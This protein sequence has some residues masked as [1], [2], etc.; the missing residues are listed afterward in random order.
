MATTIITYSADS[1][2]FNET[3]TPSITIYDGDGSIVDTGSMTHLVNGKYTYIFTATVGTSYF[4]KIVIEGREVNTALEMASAVTSGSPSEG[5][6]ITTGDYTNSLQVVRVAGIGVEIVDE[7]VG[8]GDNSEVSFDLDND[9]IIASSYTLYHG[10]SDSNVMSD[11]TETTHYSLDK[12]SGRVVLTTAGKTELGTDI[13][14]GKY[15]HS[16]KMSDTLI[17]SLIDKAEAELEAYTERQWDE[18]TEITEFFDGEENKF[19]KYP[20]TDEPFQGKYT[21]PDYIV[22]SKG[23]VTSVESVSFIVRGQTLT[24]VWTYDGTYTDNTSEANTPGGTSFLAFGSSPTTSDYLYCGMPF[25]FLSS[26]LIFDVVGAGS[27]ALVLEYWNGSAWTAISSPTDNTTNYT[28]D[29]KVSWTMPSGWAKT[30]VNGSGEYY[31][32]RFSYSG[33]LSTVPKIFEL[34]P[35]SDDVIQTEISLANID[36][37]SYGK[38][39]LLKNRIPNGPRIVKVVYNYGANE[40]PVLVQELAALYAS[41]RVFANITGGSYD[42]VTGYT[43]GSKQVS[44]GEVYVNVREVVRQ[45]TVRIDEIKRLVGGRGFFCA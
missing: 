28:K 39:S 16:P 38:L 30:T 5:E 4:A 37:A 12:A 18:L 24:Q 6:T 25:K 23:P 7:N 27:Q 34:A 44:I 8:T 11:L 22:L 13:L 31:Y 21:A 2:N 17:N 42:D 41:L 40:V 1:R 15:T 9:N 20:N 45:M 32:I 14:Y 43:L 19:A 33:T 36:Y 10:S 29:G 35:S 26:T 3:L